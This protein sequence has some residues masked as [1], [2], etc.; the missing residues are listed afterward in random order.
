MRISDWS[1][2]VC[3]SDLHHRARRATSDQRALHDRAFSR[4]LYDRRGR[5][6]GRGSL[7]RAHMLIIDCPYCGERPELEF[8][9]GG[10][11]HTERPSQPA[12]LSRSEERRGGKECV[13]TCISRWSPYHQKKKKSHSNR[14]IRPHHTLHQTKTIQ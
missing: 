14:H 2:D 5:R 1:S 10:Q 13:S 12:D 8:S 9:Y 4:R 11:A 3:S 6:R 7:R